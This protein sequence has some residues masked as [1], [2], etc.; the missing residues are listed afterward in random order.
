MSDET[1]KQPAGTDTD[2]NV[3]DDEAKEEE[4]MDVSYTT[5]AVTRWTWRPS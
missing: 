2:G 5:R 1:V 3:D 4:D